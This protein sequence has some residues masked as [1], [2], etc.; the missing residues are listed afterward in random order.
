MAAGWGGEGEGEG[1]SVKRDGQRYK[2]S[3]QRLTNVNSFE[4]QRRLSTPS[5]VIIRRN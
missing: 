1:V 5:W 2:S 4:G 3:L